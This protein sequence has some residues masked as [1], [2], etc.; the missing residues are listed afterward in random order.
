MAEV[1]RHST[2]KLPDEDL[3]AIATYLKDVDG[4]PE[5]DGGKPDAAAANAGARV[6]KDSCSGCHN[7]DGKGVP[8][9]LPPLARNANVQQRDP[10]TVLRVI[11]EGARTEPTGKRPTPFAMPAYG[12]K[13]TDAQIAAVASYVRTSWGNKGGAVDTATVESL[14][15]SLKKDLHGNPTGGS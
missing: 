15:K 11:L 9:M 7:A 14:R 2:S 8:G 3:H 5:P 1:V 10:T 12:W 4:G 6:F 13:L